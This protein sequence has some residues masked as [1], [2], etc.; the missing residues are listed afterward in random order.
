MRG[1]VIEI[2]GDAVGVKVRASGSDLAICTGIAIREM[3][4][5]LTED[6]GMEEEIKKVLCDYINSDCMEPEKLSVEIG[7][8]V[9][10]PSTSG[11]VH[12]MAEKMVEGMHRNGSNLFQSFL[13]FLGEKYADK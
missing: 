12:D 6:Y 4:R 7:S 3:V 10:I 8:R 9:V 1:I 13:D 11:K 2:N 5:K